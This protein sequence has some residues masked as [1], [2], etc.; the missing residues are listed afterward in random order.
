MLRFTATTGT[1][2]RS[3]VI[4]TGTPGRDLGPGLYDPGIRT[5][6]VLVGVTGGAVVWRRPLSS[7]FDQAGL[8]T[9]NGWNFDFVPNRGLFVGSVAG[10]PLSQ[11]ANSDVID[12]S[13]TMTAGF[14]TRDGGL[15]WTSV[16][17]Q[18]ICMILPCTGTAND[19]SGNVYRPPTFGLRIRGTGTIHVTIQ[20]LH[21]TFAPGAS[22]V[23]EGF[24]LA[25]GRTTWSFNAGQDLP[26]IQE[27]TPPEVG[28][29]T[30]VL[31]DS[32][33][34]LTTLDLATGTTAPLTSG[35]VLWCQALT[36]YKTGPAYQ[37][38]NG[39]SSTTH[40]GQNVT[41]ACNP[42]GH[43]LPTPAH[44]PTFIGPAVGGLTVWSQSDRVIA[45]PTAK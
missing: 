8:S 25:T 45:A 9:D 35:T 34:T 44:V 21:A 4:S 6:E 1:R 16:G 3:A 20:P 19:N 38:A 26:L 14:R 30:V 42:Q 12:L 10:P 2:L 17:T 40:I 33:G 32:T 43:P 41:F 27:T 22:I 39:R 37:G 23:L 24:D 36:T 29:E 18:Y 15:V 13:R 11:T 28:A 31:P 5:P 7:V